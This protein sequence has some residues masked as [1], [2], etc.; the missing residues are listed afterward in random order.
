MFLALEKG[1]TQRNQY[2]E[3]GPNRSTQLKQ[4]LTRADIRPK[5][6]TRADIR[7]RKKKNKDRHTQN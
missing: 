4:A 1:Q 7:W 2:K 3:T 5:K 6:K